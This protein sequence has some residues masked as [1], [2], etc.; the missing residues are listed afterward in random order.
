[1]A[2]PVCPYLGL[3]DDPEAH[4]NYPSFENRCYS[5]I[6]RESIQLSEQSV[7]CL[8]G[9]Y[10]SCP[11]Y[12]AVHGPP[13]ADSTIEMAPVPMPSAPPAP[14]TQAA[15][16]PVPLPTYVAPVPA[17]QPSSGRDWSLAI[18]LGG[19]LVGILLCVVAFAGYFSLRALVSTLPSTATPPVVVVIPV[20]P[21]VTPTSTI[22]PI[23]AQESPTITPVTAP[24]T[25]TITPTLDM[26]ATSTPTPLP[27]TATRPPATPT[28]RPAPTQTPRPT[29]TRAPTPV[30]TATPG[31]VVISFTATKTSILS[32]QCTTIT[33]RVTN[34]KEVHYEGRGVNGSGSSEECPTITTTY[35]LKV[36]DQRNT[37]T[38]KTL[39][40]TVNAGTPTG[41]PTASPTV[42]P[43]PT[44]TPTV[45]PS[46]TVTRTATP[47]PTPTATSTPTPTATP[48]YVEWSASPPNYTGSGPD[49]DIV[50]T[51]TGFVSDRLHLTLS[52]SQL[53]QDW[54][55]EIC[56]GSDCGQSKSTPLID[57]AG[58]TSVTVHFTIPQGAPAGSSG[59]VKLKANSVKDS[60]YRLFVNITVQ[61]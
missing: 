57:P 35:T 5:T 38:T 52:D 16:A 22:T 36:I 31:A 54:Q 55:V 50:F 6:A 14:A 15:T 34:A 61:A 47:T 20:A 4:L 9:Q 53:P 43:W 48:F 41:T 23:P 21:S 44:A 33:W 18:I 56:L 49:V 59:S 7:F 58:V 51:N 10:Q 45:T 13:Q 39:K 40:I 11:R 3:L 8:G 42:T 24:A 37:V 17:A 46:P 60:A 29:S 30:R 12:M 1:M 19:M 25:P 26:Q 2:T 28:R 32:G 27:G